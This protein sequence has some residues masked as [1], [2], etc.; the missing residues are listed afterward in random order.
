M[1][2]KSILAATLITFAAITSSYAAPATPAQKTESPIKVTKDEKIGS[3]K[4][5]CADI[6]DPN[7]KVSNKCTIS[8]TATKKVDGKDVPVVSVEIFKT[9]GENV[10]N[11]LA[12]LNVF[13]PS[14][15]GIEIDGQKDKT[16]KVPFI[17]CNPIGC[18][19]EGKMAADLIE[20]LKKGSNAKVLVNSI[21]EGKKELPISLNGLGDAMAKLN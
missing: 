13:L 2:N 6:K 4:Y 11:V 12:P 18:K 8:Q 16:A 17:Y 10:V 7:G 3:W 20:G 9:Q 5:I 1:F 19:A 15:A 14:G 21:Y